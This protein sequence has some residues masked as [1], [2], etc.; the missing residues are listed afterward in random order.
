MA[1]EQK[2]LV[3]IVLGSKSDLTYAQETERVLAKLGVAHETRVLSAHRMPEATTEYARTAQDR[4]LRVI[5]AM[6]GL[7]AHLPG[8][9]ASHTTLPVIG[10]PLSGGVMGGLDA[11]LSIVSM[12]GGVP[13]ACVALDKPGARNAGILAAQILAGS[14]PATAGAVAELKRELAGGGTV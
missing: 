1:D 2:A 11:L 9:I 10:V 3:G 8:V 14:D 5:I 12:P 6:A 7:A 13:V 4:G